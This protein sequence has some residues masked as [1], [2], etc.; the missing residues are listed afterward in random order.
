MNIVTALQ[1]F[2]TKINAKRDRILRRVIERRNLYP[3]IILHIAG[4]VKSAN[5]EPIDPKV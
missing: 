2:L 1:V 3:P 4:A 5:I